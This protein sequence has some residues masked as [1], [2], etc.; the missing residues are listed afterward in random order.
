MWVKTLVLGAVL[1]WA[2]GAAA[3][4]SWGKNC[5]HA[6]ADAPATPSNT[7][8]LIGAGEHAGGLPK[9]ACLA[10]GTT[11]IDPSA[12]L[13]VRADSVLF[14]LLPDTVS[15]GTVATAMVRKCP[16][17]NTLDQDDETCLNILDAALDGTAGAPGTQ[18]AS[19][20]AGPGCYN[21][22]TVA[23]GVGD[24]PVLLAEAEE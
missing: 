12:T 14:T 24:H 22:V 8:T 11:T 13:Q 6:S 3:S 10:W 15:T 17:D 20:R 9:M 21:V 5:A 16:C 19:V 7:I 18:N 23:G 2:S 4:S 1:L